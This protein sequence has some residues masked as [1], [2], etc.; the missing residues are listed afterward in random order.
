MLTFKNVYCDH[1]SMMCFNEYEN[2]NVH[3]PNI[4]YE[5]REVETIAIL[6]LRKKKR[7]YGVLESFRNSRQQEEFV[8]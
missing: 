5:K 7:G 3:T 6:T 8:S 2:K 4:V 1:S